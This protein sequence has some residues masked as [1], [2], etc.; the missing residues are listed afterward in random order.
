MRSN[1]GKGDFF[2]QVAAGGAAV[3]TVVLETGRLFRP[4]HDIKGISA[5]YDPGAE[6]GGKAL[7]VQ[8]TRAAQP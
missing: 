1:N 6:R 2:H 7:L 4:V 3:A 8:C 5:L